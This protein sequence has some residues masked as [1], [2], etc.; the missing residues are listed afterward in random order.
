MSRSFL[1][2]TNVASEQSRPRPE[3]LVTQ[4]LASQIPD[5]VFLSV[6]TIGELRKGIALLPQSKRRGELTEWF[7]GRLA[8]GFA[9]RILPVTQAIGD[10]WGVLTAMRQLAG[11]PLAAPDGLIAATAL[12]HDLTLVTC[13]VDDFVG[14]GVPLL[15]PWD[16]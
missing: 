7:D 9:G 2:D 16:A 5:A 8:P 4:W 14:L 1:L 12:E 6:V 13:N 11:I 15:N 3:P 10:R